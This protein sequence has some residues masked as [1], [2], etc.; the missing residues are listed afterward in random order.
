MSYH[1]IAFRLAI[2][3][4]QTITNVCE[5]MKKLENLNTACAD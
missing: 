2:K 3:K 1:F 5:D 4:R